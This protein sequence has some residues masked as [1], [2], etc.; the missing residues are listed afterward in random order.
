MGFG[1]Q[2]HYE[3]PGNLQVGHVKCVP[4][5]ISSHLYFLLFSKVL[6]SYIT[7]QWGRFTVKNTTLS[8]YI[9]F[10]GIFCFFYNKNCVYII[11]ISFLMKVE[12]S[13]FHNRLLTNQRPEQVIINC[14]WNC[15]CNSAVINIG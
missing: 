13:N 11:F 1:T 6:S 4:L 3:I 15:M 5:T 9:N 10:L 8:S 2:P 12:V 14:Q 7:G